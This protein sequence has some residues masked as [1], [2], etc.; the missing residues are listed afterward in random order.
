MEKKII[1]FSSSG[2]S[3][4]LARWGNRAAVWHTDQGIL[5]DKKVLD[6]IN[7]T[8][9]IKTNTFKKQANTE[10]TNMASM[11]MDSLGQI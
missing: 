11:K 6:P 3:L 9:Y 4:I 1:S 10:R 5:H 8:N 7:K 2:D